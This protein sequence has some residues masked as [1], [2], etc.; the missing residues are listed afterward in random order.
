MPLY[1]MILITVIAVLLFSMFIVVI[2][3]YKKCPSDKIMVI[4]GNVGNN[5]DGTTRSS[6]CIHGGAAFVWPII[7]AY[8]FLDLTPISISVDLTNALSKQ[9]IRIDVPSRFT[10]GISTEQG[11]MQNAAERVLGLRLNEVQELSKDIIFGQLRLIIATMDIE[12]INTDRDKFLEAV[13]GNVETELR[14]IGLRLI[15]VNVT[16]INDESGYIAA[17]GKEAAAKAINDAKK[18]VAEKDRDGAIGEANATRDQRIQVATANSAAIQG[19]NTARITIANSE[20]E[21][22]EK[23]AEALKIAVSAEKIQEAQ[24]QEAS[25]AAQ[26]LAET[27][28]AQREKATLEADVIIQA[29]IAKRKLEL[30]AEAQAEQTRRRAR[31][32]ADAIY[33]KMEAEARGAQEILVK[34][35]LGL[36][37]VVEAAGGDPNSALRLMLADK[38]EELLRIQV[39]AIKNIKFDKVTVW[40]SG[41]GAGGQTSTANFLSGL[42]KSLPP[43]NELFEMTGMQLPEFLGKTNNESQ[44]SPVQ[45]ETP[46]ETAEE[47]PTADAQ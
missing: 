12:E 7:Q 13:S 25:Y 1:V 32:E 21:L 19:E 44:V 34:Q 39:D 6:R 37:K 18:S 41:T 23:Q 31:G 24:A 28:R 33:A 26:Q 5:K 27:A 10:V 20:A 45:D 38:M 2:S 47:A 11:V 9:N 46:D 30:E 17:L 22:R 29:E 16:D 15:N 43:I 4:Y 14:K 8:A 42:M 36:T 3:R 40:D 35:A